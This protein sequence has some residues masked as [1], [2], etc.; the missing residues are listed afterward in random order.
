[1][2]RFELTPDHITLLRAAY[3]SWDDC[4]FGAPAIDP[5]RP[6]GNSSVVIDIAEML[7]IAPDDGE[8]YSNAT[9]DRLTTLHRETQTAL[10]V[11]L[12]TGSFEPGMYEAPP[13]SRRWVRV[14]PQ[15]PSDPE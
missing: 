9:T 11:V 7:G 13:Y 2:Q 6:Y 10:Q 3:V 14:Y 8:T 5:K 15:T 4:E 12:A 1:M